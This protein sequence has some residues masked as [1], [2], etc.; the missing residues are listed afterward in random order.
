MGNDF[1]IAAAQPM[2]LTVKRGSTVHPEVILKPI[3]GFT[4]CINLFVNAG[5]LPYATWAH[6]ET[7]PVCFG[8]KD[9]FLNWVHQATSE[10][11]FHPASFTRPGTYTVKITG[12]GNGG[13]GL[14]NHSTFININVI[15]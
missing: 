1:S 9:G 8:Q 7:N 5:T 10:M 6:M 2:N 3:G 15:P 13:S 14:M 11:H 12:M 4:G